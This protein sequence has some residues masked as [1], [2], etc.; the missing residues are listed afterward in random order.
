VNDFFYNWLI[1]I[2]LKKKVYFCNIKILVY[3]ECTGF[4]CRLLIL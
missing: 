3:C 1:A 2:N 4:F